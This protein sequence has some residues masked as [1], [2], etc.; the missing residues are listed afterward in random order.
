M[1]VICQRCSCSL[2]LRAKGS[3]EG[4]LLWVDPQL[5]ACASAI[6][7]A[8][9]SVPEGRELTLATGDGAGGLAPSS[10]SVK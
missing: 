4:C 6:D 3:G 10:D 8:E 2:G 1:K 9:P 5:K 7:S